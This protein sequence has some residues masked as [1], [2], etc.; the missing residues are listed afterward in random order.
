MNSPVSRLTYWL[1]TGALSFALAVVVAVLFAMNAASEAR[2]RAMVSRLDAQRDV[3]NAQ[4]ELLR[5]LTAA[6]SSDGQ[7]TQDSVKL[8]E[9]HH[10]RIAKAEAQ[11]ELQAMDIAITSNHLAA[12]ITRLATR[13]A[14]PTATA[15]R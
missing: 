12:A 7:F 3:N 4:S 9:D 10:E 6:G 1:T 8:L 13:P 2:D 11:L 15:R 5:A 14:A